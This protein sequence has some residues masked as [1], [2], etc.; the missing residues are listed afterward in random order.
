MQLLGEEHAGA[1]GW[2][3]PQFVHGLVIITSSSLTESEKERQSCAIRRKA[4]A[5]L[6][7]LDG[8]YHRREGQSKEHYII[9]KATVL[10]IEKTFKTDGDVLKT[11]LSKI[12]ETKRRRKTKRNRH[13][14]ISLAR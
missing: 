6:H 4:L 1:A 8:Q 12:I 13:L 7:K 9:W 14:L 2:L 10:S 3:P 11:S 5:A